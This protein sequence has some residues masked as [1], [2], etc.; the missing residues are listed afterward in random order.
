MLRDSQPSKASRFAELYEY[1]IPY[2]HFLRKFNDLV[3]FT[4]IYE[5]LRNKYSLDNGRNAISPI[6]LFKY[7]LLKVIYNMSDVDLVERS[8]YDMSFK[9]FLGLCPEDNVIHPSTLTKFRKLRLQDENLLDLLIQKSIEIALAKNIIKSNKIIVDATHTKA[10]YNQRSAYECLLE[11]A[12]VLRK[13][14]YQIDS[15]ARKSSFP[16]KIENGILEDALEYCRK[17][18]VAVD[19]DN[20]IAEIPSI[21]EKLNLLKEM[22]DDNVE[23]LNSSKDKDARVGHKTADT[24][25][26]GYKTHIAMTDERIITAATVTSGEHGDGEQLK[27]LVEKTRKLGLTVKSVI[28]DTAYSGKRNL[29]LAESKAAPEKAFE[30][31]AKLNPVISNS[32]RSEKE[33]GFTYNKDADLF[34]CPAGHMAIR[35]AK[36]I[37]TKKGKNIREVYYFDIEKCK[38]CIQNKNCYKEGKKSKTYSVTIKCDLHKKQ[39][40]FQKTDYFKE[41]ANNRYMIE[42]KNSELKHRHGYDVASFSGLV[43]MELQGATTLFVVNI[44]RIMK[45]ISK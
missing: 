14:V 43:G 33:S 18:I 16:K 41:N 38:H 11:Q 36:H 4:F 1:L 27:A 17:L 32:V 20:T 8:R 3:D 13:V 42:A 15:P 39:E 9:Y 22:V 35:K 34:V 23:H 30:L 2:D 21:K 19:S 5:E 24:S 40:E 45:L 25:F 37:P 12:K 29:E 28:G 44:K 31:I 7:L 26:F 10:R 6:M